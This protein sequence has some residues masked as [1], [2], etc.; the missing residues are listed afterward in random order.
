MKRKN[1]KTAAASA[2]P[3][4]DARFAALT[5]DDLEYFADTRSV[6][7]GKGYVSRVSGICVDGKG[8][9]MRTL[10]MRMEQRGV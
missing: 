1:G 6:K 2:E 8:E 5:W 7:R 3:E 10:E 4:Y 9:A